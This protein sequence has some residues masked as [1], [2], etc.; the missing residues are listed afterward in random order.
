LDIFKYNENKK[1]E[2][3]KNDFNS[4]YLKQEKNWNKL[5]SYKK[6]KEK[7]ILLML[8]NF[9]EDLNKIFLTNLS[10]LEGV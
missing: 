4:S 6:I 8:K 1:I 10:E 9:L 5:L 3:L 7:I 2:K